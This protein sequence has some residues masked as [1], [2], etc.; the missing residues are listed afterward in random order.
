MGESLDQ[1][2]RRLTAYPECAHELLLLKRHAE[3]GSLSRAL[4]DFAKRVDLPETDQLAALLLRGSHLGTELVGSLALQAEHLR[5]ARRQSAAIQANKTPVKMIFPIMF[6]FA[7]AA[8][9][10]LTAP[11]IMQLRDFL[12]GR[13]S[14]DIFRH[15][16]AA[17]S[18]Q[19]P[20]EAG[21]GTQ[22]IIGEV[23]KLDQSRVNTADTTKHP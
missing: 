13:T 19:E 8:L 16:M 5:V 18:A 7:P 17:V 9:I 21:F 12:T 20:A 6:C 23:Q 11:A 4:A 10:L 14:Q 15:D 1:V 22:Y 3:L 2:A